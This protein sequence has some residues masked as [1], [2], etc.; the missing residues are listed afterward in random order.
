M[1]NVDD[2]VNTIHLC[3]AVLCLFRQ[4]KDTGWD[5]IY[6]SVAQTGAMGECPVVWFCG[7]F[8]CAV[9]TTMYRHRADRRK[10]GEGAVGDDSERGVATND[11][12]YVDE[13]F[14]LSGGLRI[15]RRFVPI[16]TEG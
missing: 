11:D 4:S 7:L 2:D 15:C 16:A 9:S 13:G 6:S 8:Y 5:G 1:K 3:S 12:L 14:V 10:Y